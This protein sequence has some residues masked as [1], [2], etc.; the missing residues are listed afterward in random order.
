MLFNSF[1]MSF[2]LVYDLPEDQR[3]PCV[4]ILN[5]MLK[6]KQLIHSIG[7]EFSLDQVVQAHQTVEAGKTIGNVV[8]NIAH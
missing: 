5:A 3:E 2:F 1:T 6:S 4:Y 8:I 7:A